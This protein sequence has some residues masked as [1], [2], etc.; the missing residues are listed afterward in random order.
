MLLGV[1]SE[2]PN[3]GYIYLKPTKP[4]QGFS[5][6]KITTE[7]D[8]VLIKPNVLLC[9]SA[10]DV[11]MGIASI[12]ASAKKVT[13]N[14]TVP[15]IRHHDAITSQYDWYHGNLPPRLK[16]LVS[17]RHTS[18]GEACQTHILSGLFYLEWFFRP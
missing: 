9:E 17:V 18:S 14:S 6:V 11:G 8:V 16:P 2:D 13:G 15:P 5:R 4:L 7:G 10:I 3:L 1:T 12:A